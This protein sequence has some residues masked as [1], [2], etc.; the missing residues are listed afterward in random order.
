M[1]RLHWILAVVVVLAGQLFAQEH[2]TEGP[3][4]NVTLI[5][6]KPAQFDA[7]LTNLQQGA[8]LA[9]DEAKRQGVIMDYKVFIKSTQEN[10]HD[11]D[12]AIA[13]LYRNHTQMDGLTAKMEA[14]RDKVLGGKQAAQQ[15]AEKRTEIREIVGTM[16]LQE[17]MLK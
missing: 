17:I 14:V 3:V 13:V 4:W 7:Y 1:T 5:R 16:L 15:A 10:P 6:T 11:W 12:I 9:Y 2:Y 8:K